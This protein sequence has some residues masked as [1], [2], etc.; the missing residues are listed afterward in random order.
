MDDVDHIMRL[1]DAA[2][3][4]HWGEAWTRRQVLDALQFPYTNYQLIDGEENFE[5]KDLPAAGF[6]LTRRVADEEELLLIAVDPSYRKRGIGARLIQEL[7]I[8]ARESGISR[9][10]LEMRANNPA[11]TLY[12]SFGFEPVGKRMGYYKMRDGNF[13]D[14][15]T[16]ARNVDKLSNISESFS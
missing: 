8:K 11:K 15:I 1:M 4:P 14:A 12:T 3:D 7:V 6:T 10:F 5:V 13:V 2:F 9:I 16:Y